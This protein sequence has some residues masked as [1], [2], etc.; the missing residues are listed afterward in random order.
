MDL[1]RRVHDG[2]LGTRESFLGESGIRG[3]FFSLRFGIRLLLGQCRIRF[4]AGSLSNLIIGFGQ[5]FVGGRFGVFLGFCVLAFFFQSF[6]GDVRQF[7]GLFQARGEISDFLLRLFQRLIL[8]GQFDGGFGH[9]ICLFN[10]GA[11]GSKIALDLQHDLASGGAPDLNLVVRTCGGDA[12][13]VGT[14][15]KGR[16]RRAML[17]ITQGLGR[18]LIDQ[19]HRISGCR[20]KLEFRSL[21][22]SWCRH[23]AWF[24]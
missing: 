8:P 18:W 15:H 23:C 20:S 11:L 6:L 2:G 13:G 17:E 16:D 14:H 24:G 3:R 21:G 7:I 9:G 5:C 12:L 10:H 4:A 22:R 1:T 19:R